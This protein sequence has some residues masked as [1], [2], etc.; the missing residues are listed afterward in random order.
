VKTFTDKKINEWVNEFVVK[1]KTILEST[2]LAI[3]EI[4]FSLN[5]SDVSSFS[6]FLFCSYHT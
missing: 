2:E 1:T 5:F 4:S 6:D 3:Q